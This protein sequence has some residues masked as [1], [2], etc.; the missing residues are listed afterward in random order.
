MLV[1]A[2]SDKHQSRG[3]YGAVEVT[4]LMTMERYSHGIRTS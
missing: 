1:G 3:G 4:E 2:F